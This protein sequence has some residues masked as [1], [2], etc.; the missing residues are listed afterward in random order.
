VRNSECIIPIPRID[1]APQ[2]VRQLEKFLRGTTDNAESVQ[3]A[4]LVLCG[5]KDRIFAAL[6]VSRRCIVGHH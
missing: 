5:L 1:K 4:R 6:P 2:M 3:L